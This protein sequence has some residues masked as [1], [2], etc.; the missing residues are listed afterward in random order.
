MAAQNLTLGLNEA[1]FELVFGAYFEANTSSFAG[2]ITILDTTVSYAAQAAPSVTLGGS[3]SG[4]G[5]SAGSAGNASVT[6]DPVRVTVQGDAPVDL[7]LTTSGL[8]TLQGGT[9]SIT[10]LST[11]IEGAGGWLDRAIAKQVD[12]HLAQ[13]YEQL[14]AHINV[15]VLG[16]IFNTALTVALD[17][18]TIAGGLCAVHGS[19]T[20]QGYGSADPL[21]PVVGDAASATPAIGI[22]T[23][24]SG[25][26][27]VLFTQRSRFPLVAPVKEIAEKPASVLGEFGAGIKG[28]IALS[29]PRLS[30]SGGNASAVSDVT[31]VL[32][33][34]I[35]AFSSWTWVPL[36]IP[37]TTAD[38]F[39]ALGPDS[40][41]RVAELSLTGL[42]GVSV[43]VDW[44]SVLAPA[45]DTLATLLDAVVNDFR[46]AIGAALRTF[47]FPVFTLPDTVPGIA[48]PVH[49]SFAQLAFA[50]SGLASILHGT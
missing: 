26:Q 37:D 34:G 16:N 1:L 2:S 10:S 29:F 4:S 6:F 24:A 49:L 30:V 27:L 45:G 18:A 3:G 41:G 32:Q 14:L 20:Y 50:Q 42:G 22:A 23:N 33:G 25:L 43:H 36:P 19:M 38:L 28:T 39:V 17:D 13:H 21:P 9:L 5:S 44:P 40:T 47:S 46:S 31:F 11:T 12:A 8:V 15:P 48:R 35:E 7:T